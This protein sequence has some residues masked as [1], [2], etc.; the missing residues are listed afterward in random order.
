MPRLSIKTHILTIFLLLVSTLSFSLLFSQYY[1][2]EKLAIDS[3]HKT[4]HII[5]KNIS[6]HIHKEAVAT[7]KILNLK[8]KHKNLLEPI[9]FDPLHPFFDNMAQVLQRNS[10]LHA[11]YFAHA[12]GKFYEVIHM[13][14][15]P[16]LFKTFH[17]PVS[18]HWTI[19][20]I[21]D[22]QQQ[23]AFLDKNFDF[24]SQTRFDKKYDI[25]SRPWYA[26]AIH[27]TDI[28]ITQPYLFSNSHQMGMTYAKQ[29]ERKGVVLALDYTMT[30]L[31]DILTLQKFDQQS[32]VF[33]VDNNAKKFASSAFANSDTPS[34]NANT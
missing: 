23:N 6:E 13:Q 28:I 22:N 30:Q 7:R 19:V 3:T 27:S 33:L 4:F 1:F 32:E 16:H 11:I 21:I 5:S 31:N 34:S 24:I 9:T 2:S 15:R 29:F 8:S 26:N 25:H 18:T 20:T 12:N 10:N 17:A 14:D